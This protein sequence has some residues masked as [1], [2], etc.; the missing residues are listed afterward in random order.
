MPTPSSAHPGQRVS[1]VRVLGEPIGDRVETAVQAGELSVRGQDAPGPHRV[2]PGRLALL[3]AEPSVQGRLS[4]LREGVVQFLLLRRAETAPGVTRQDDY[5]ELLVQRHVGRLHGRQG[6]RSELLHGDLDAPQL[7]PG[8][9]LAFAVHGMISVRAELVQDRLHSGVLADVDEL[10][11]VVIRSNE[12]LGP[13]AEGVS[14]SAG[15]HSEPD[16][17]DVVEA[18][19]QLL[20]QLGI[21]GDGG[22]LV[23]VGDNERRP[24]RCQGPCSK[25]LQKAGADHGDVGVAGLQGLDRVP[26]FAGV[27]RAR[28]TDGDVDRGVVGDADELSEHVF[29]DT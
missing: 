10:V 20:G 9:Q 13:V 29:T 2:A 7:L 19:E 12:G 27:A 8:C 21:R 25:L 23:V 28:W 11:A 22:G 3:L 15:H 17:P 1:R 14:E 6:H 26:L 5:F 18:A 16:D 4:R 24:Q